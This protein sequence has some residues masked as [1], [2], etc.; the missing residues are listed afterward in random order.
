MEERGKALLEELA[1]CGL[2]GGNRRAFYR[3]GGARELSVQG[4]GE[5]MCVKYRNH[6]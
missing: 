4:V 5:K 3:S 6:T 2:A 1:L